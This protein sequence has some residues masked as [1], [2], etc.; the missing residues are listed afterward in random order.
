M[1]FCVFIFNAKENILLILTS[2][3]VQLSEKTV[4]LHQLSTEVEFLR[5]EAGRFRA[6]ANK[7]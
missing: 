3:Y 5:R 6:T 7:R 4:T 2:F 1:V